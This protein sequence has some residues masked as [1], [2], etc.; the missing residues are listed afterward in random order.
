MAQ[1]ARMTADSGGRALAPEELPQL[2]AE[3]ADRQPEVKQEVLQR[4][5]YWDTWPFFLL[6][7]ALLGIEWYLRKRWGLV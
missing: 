3:L 4:V 2:L 1:L 7:V 6:F 5:T